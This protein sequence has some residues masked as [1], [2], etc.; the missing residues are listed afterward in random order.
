IAKKRIEELEQKR[1]KTDATIQEYR[2]APSST[3]IF[4]TF[5]P[6]DDGKQNIP[7]DLLMKA[8]EHEIQ[9]LDQKLLIAR[10]DSTSQE[11]NAE[12]EL[13]KD[14]E[15]L[16]RSYFDQKKS[17]IESALKELKTT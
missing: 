4:S 8:I 17:S 2:E 1:E 11:K 6:P 14:R 16:Y 7:P 10:L 12:K 15:T 5:F 3:S 9:I 13:K